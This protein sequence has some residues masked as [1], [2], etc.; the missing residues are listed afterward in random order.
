[1]EDGDFR[2]MAEKDAF[3][4]TEV[5]GELEEE[6]ES[7]EVSISMESGRVIA[8]VVKTP[9]GTPM[10]GAFVVIAREERREGGDDRGRG[11][12][13]RGDDRGGRDGEEEEG[14]EKT[15][16]DLEKERRREEERQREPVSVYRSSL[17][18]ETERD[19]TFVADT[20][21][22]GT[23]TLSVQGEFFVPHRVREIDLDEKER[24]DLDIVVDPG[25]QLKGEV[26]SSVDEPRVNSSLV[27]LWPGRS[28]SSR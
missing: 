23:Y 2:I 8:G 9:D 6:A 24:A 5:N 28:E 21:E 16:E 4:T 26:V 18:L 7:A 12:G 10:A 11:R 13:G 1:M 15:P 19:G 25:L 27:V 14:K 20:L 17:A 3:V 22:K